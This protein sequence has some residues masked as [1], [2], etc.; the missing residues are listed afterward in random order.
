MMP[1]AQHNRNL[2]PMKFLLIL[3][4]FVTLATSHLG[5]SSLFIPTNLKEFIVGRRFQRTK[6]SAKILFFSLLTLFL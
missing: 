6:P 1:L 4:S 3:F 2:F 5:K